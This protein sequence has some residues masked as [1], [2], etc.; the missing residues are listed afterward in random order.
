MRFIQL[1]G[2]FFAIVIPISVQAYDLNSYRSGEPYHSIIADKIEVCA[3]QCQG[4]AQCKGWNFVTVNRMS[5]PAYGLCEFNSRVANP[6][7]SSS[8]VSGQHDA[9]RYSRV[10]IPGGTASVQ[11]IG[12]VPQGRGGQVVGLYPFAPLLQVQPM[13]D[14]HVA[15]QPPF[16]PGPVVR[17]PG[18]VVVNPLPPPPVLQGPYPT[19][20]YARPQVIPSQVLVEPNLQTHYAPSVPVVRGRGIHLPTSLPAPISNHIVSSPHTSIRSPMPDPPVYKPDPELSTH[21]YRPRKR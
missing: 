6:E 17:R 21:T 11:R 16:T 7:Y 4:D 10:P 1:Y 2:L 15:V 14:H 3:A 12:V 13:L 8:S 5:T 18:P 20:Q 9:F 19:A